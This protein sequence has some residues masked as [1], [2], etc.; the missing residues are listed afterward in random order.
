MPGE[1]T[2]R[3]EAE[4]F[5]RKVAQHLADRAPAYACKFHPVAPLPAAFRGINI[6]LHCLFSATHRSGHSWK[7]CL[8]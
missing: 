4:A 6:F 8:A 5:M 7:P 1:T 2:P 3:D